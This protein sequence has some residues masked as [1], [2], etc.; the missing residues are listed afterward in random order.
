MACRVTGP[1]QRREEDAWGHGAW[2]WSP[3]PRRHAPGMAVGT[4][5]RVAEW[6]AGSRATCDILAQLVVL[7]TQRTQQLEYAILLHQGQLVV[8]IVV[9]KVAHGARGVALHL[10]VGVVEELHQPSHS[11]QAAGLW[12]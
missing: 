7:L 3:T 8:R 10:L 4:E 9:D 5:G 11:L 1:Q 6:R 12:A 2:G